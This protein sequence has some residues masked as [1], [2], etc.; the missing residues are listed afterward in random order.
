MFTH[1]RLKIQKRISK[2]QNQV[3][4]FFDDIMIDNSINI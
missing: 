4:I 3:L 1:Y 2:R